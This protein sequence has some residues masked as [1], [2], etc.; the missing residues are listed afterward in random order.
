MSYPPG[1]GGEVN[2]LFLQHLLGDNCQQ[3]DAAVHAPDAHG[4]AG[5]VDA[6]AREGDGD[7][8]GERD[9]GGG[10]AAGEG[11]CQ[12]HSTPPARSCS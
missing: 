9:E 2:R 6:D 11:G 12:G 10:L 5:L 8:P 7:G 4:D 3:V 1:A